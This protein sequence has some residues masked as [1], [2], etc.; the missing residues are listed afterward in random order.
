MMRTRVLVV[1]LSALAFAA[2]SS[3]SSTTSTVA[4]PPAPAGAAAAPSA[5]ADIE[6][7][8]G[9]TVSGTA[10]FTETGDGVRVSVDVSGAPEGVHAV[11]LH[12]KGDC[13]APD[14][15]SAGGHFNP[16]GMPHGAPDAP[17][18]HAGDFGNMT[19]GADGKG[20]VALTTRMLTVS[21][22]PN[23]VLGRGIIVHAKADDLQTQ[24]TGNAG[25]RI[26]CGVVR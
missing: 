14:A 11:H 21:A 15:T 10:T 26:G 5:K 8:S 23:S 9:S 24:P 6:A 3:S 1:I 18:H 20:H 19:V 7:R 25:G 16:S 12:E 22:G 13:S 17:N 4:A 2:C